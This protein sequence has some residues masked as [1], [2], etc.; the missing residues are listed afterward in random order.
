MIDEL[1]THSS[2][3]LS[4]LTLMSAVRQALCWDWK[5]NSAHSAGRREGC[6]K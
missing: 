3:H 6:K 4:K 1:V 5:N 2:F